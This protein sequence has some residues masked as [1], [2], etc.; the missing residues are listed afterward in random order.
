MKANLGGVREDIPYF[1][2]DYLLVFIQRQ[3]PDALD[4]FSMRGLFGFW[5]K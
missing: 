1:R 3:C 2:T 4:G 5:D